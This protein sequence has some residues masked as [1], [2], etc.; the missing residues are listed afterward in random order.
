MNLWPLDGGRFITLPG[1]VT[2]DPDSGERNVG[3]Y[4]MQVYDERTTGMHWQLQK[5]GARHGR[6][7]HRALAAPTASPPLHARRLCGKGIA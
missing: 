4:R 3:M 6:R 2:Q 7:Y 5:V 1:V